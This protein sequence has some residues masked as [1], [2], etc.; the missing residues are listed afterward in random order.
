MEGR[1]QPESQSQSVSAAERCL[2][3]AKPAVA[4]CL[5]LMLTSFDVLFARLVP[6]L[7]VGFSELKARADA[8]Q[9]EAARQRQLVSQLR[10]KVAVLAQSHTLKNTTRASAALRRQVTLH[11]RLLSSARKAAALLPPS[12]APAGQ[13]RGASG[14]GNVQ[15][16]VEDEK[17]R[18]RLEQ[19]EGELRNGKLKSRVNELWAGL[20][21]VKARRGAASASGN[22]S[23]SGTAE[24]AV[25][26][27]EALDEVAGVSLSA[28]PFSFSCRV[29]G[30]LLW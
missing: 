1:S 13:A 16:N 11:H 4:H 3:F 5:W 15:A 14:F 2:T 8:Q 9:N 30:F 18:S 22:G 29:S 12:A 23:S 25:V 19:C 6:V 17:L 26:D 27:A 20:G 24:W 7:A 10:E 21:A 28:P